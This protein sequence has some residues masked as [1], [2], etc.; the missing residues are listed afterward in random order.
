[1]MAAT[2]PPIWSTSRCAA[3]H[4]TVASSSRRAITA[5]DARR[6][7]PGGGHR[8]TPERHGPPVG[9]SDQSHHGDEGR[10]GEDPDGGVEQAVD[11]RAHDNCDRLLVLGLREVDH[12]V[13]GPEADTPDE[14]NSERDA[15]RELEER[16]PPV[17]RHPQRE[18]DQD[19][20]QHHRDDDEAVEQRHRILDSVEPLGLEHGELPEVIGQVPPQRRFDLCHRVLG[21]VVDGD[22]GQVD[23]PPE[24][25][26]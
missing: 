7:R 16:A 10:S 6:Q 19:D 9:T 23:R 14:D 5:L 25:L 1:M 24:D 21:Y 26:G 13:L 8:A 11:E 17:G 22:G 20:D 18:W 12:L 15:D 4:A 2:I 3:T